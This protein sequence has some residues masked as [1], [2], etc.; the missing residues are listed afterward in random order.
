MISPFFPQSRGC[1]NSASWNFT[2]N[3]LMGF[4]KRRFFRRITCRI[5]IR[6]QGATQSQ[7]INVYYAY[8]LF[9]RN[10]IGCRPYIRNDNK[11]FSEKSDISI[12]CFDILYD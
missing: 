2:V 6:A 4:K 3:E 12:F 1:I 10:I 9:F 8:R 11:V 5:A 7:T